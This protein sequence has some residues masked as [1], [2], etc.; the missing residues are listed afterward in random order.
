[1]FKLVRESNL[2]FDQVI[3]EFGS[4]VHVSYN[5]DGNRKQVLIARKVN[6]KTTYTPV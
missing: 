6:G 3:D 5:K 4:W 1:L 2:P